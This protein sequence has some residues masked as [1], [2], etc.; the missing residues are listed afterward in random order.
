MTRTSFRRSIGGEIFTGIL[1]WGFKK[2]GR[3]P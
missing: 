1:S 2:R 3:L